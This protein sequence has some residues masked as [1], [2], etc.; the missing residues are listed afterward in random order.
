MQR[1]IQL[2]KSNMGTVAPN[3]MVGCV[4]IEKDEIIGEGFTSAYGGPHAEVNAIESVRD[5]SRLVNAT[6]Y[7]SLEPCS[8]FGKTPPCAD[9]IIKHNIPN[10]VIGAKDPHEKVA[11]NG[12]SKLENAGCNVREGFLEEECIR[13]NR[14]FFTYHQKKRPYI[15]L[16][17]AQSGDGL[18]A[19][20]SELRGSNPEPYWISHP[21]SQQLVHQWRTQ[22]QAIL[23]GTNTV[24]EDDPQL[25]AFL[26]ESFEYRLILKYTTNKAE[27]CYLLSKKIYRKIKS[28]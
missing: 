4:I 7:V 20:G 25:T 6:L 28:I 19:P 10:V 23:V 13:L 14:R 1:C 22:E 3:P 21:Y 12:I 2:A 27:P 26:T 17:W 8:H 15:I 24:L 5:K 9:L 18:I 16:K 11:G